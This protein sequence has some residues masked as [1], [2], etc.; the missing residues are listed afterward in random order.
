MFAIEEVAAW[1]NADIVAHIEEFKPVGHNFQHGYD[2]ESQFWFVRFYDQRQTDPVWEDYSPDERLA[3][4]N[5]FGWVW[6]SS[7]P[8]PAPGSAW[9]RRQELTPKAVTKKVALGGHTV[10]DP[11]DIDPLEVQAVYQ[12][13][14]RSK[15]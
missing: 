10:P 1:S 15:R 4:Y 2:R 9:H 3:L 12:T 11:E 14:T 13:T 6:A 5:A 8:A 7:Q